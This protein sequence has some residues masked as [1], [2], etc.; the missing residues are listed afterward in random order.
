MKSK[1]L[2]LIVL[3][4]L[5]AWVQIAKAISSTTIQNAVTTNSSG[6]TFVI[7]SFTHV[8]V[9][10]TITGAARVT[11]QS[12]QV[13]SPQV[14]K[15]LTCVNADT[16]IRLSII[17]STGNY[18][19]V[20]NGSINFQ[21]PVS[22]CSGCTVTVK[23]TGS[24]GVA[25]IPIAD[26]ALSLVGGGSTSSVGAS[27]AVQASNGSGAFLDSGLT[28]VGGLLTGRWQYNLPSDTPVVYETKSASTSMVTTGINQMIR[29][30]GVYDWVD[31]CG[32]Y[33]NLVQQDG[34]NIDNIG[35]KLNAS[36]GGFYQGMESNY[37]INL[38]PPQLGPEWYIRLNP[39]GGGGAR[40]L[41][42]GSYS[43]DG[44]YSSLGINATILGFYNH[45][46]TQTMKMDTSAT[47]WNTTWYGRT[48]TEPHR[49]QGT[50]NGC[51]WIQQRNGDDTAYNNY[52]CFK[53]ING[54]TAGGQEF[55][56]S[57]SGSIPW[58]LTV[59][60][61]AASTFA[62]SAFAIQ[63]TTMASNDAIVHVQGP[64]TN[65][66]LNAVRAVGGHLSND[67][68]VLIENSGGGNALLSLQS[69]S[70]AG[71]DPF[72]RYY[73]LGQYW[74]HGI[75]NSVTGSPWKLSASNVLGTNDRLSVTTTGAL[76]LGGNC[77]SSAATAACVDALAGSVVIAAAGL[78]VTVNT[79]AVTANSQIFIM[80]D[81][82]LGTKLGVTC[83]T[84]LARTYAVTA[85][86]AGTSFVITTSAAPATFPA[87]LSYLVVN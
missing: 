12:T 8:L 64:G 55:A 34:F 5:V 57:T 42:G 18:T 25:A 37:C 67:W 20:V 62:T 21:A 48:S 77:T 81:S 1:L 61:Q 58:Y 63:S 44:T 66:I 70:T 35:N 27:G 3:I 80:E 10:T 53:D 17:E 69:D 31:T 39:T 71:G 85:R 86:T 76:T 52:P 68:Q 7:G 60:P 56:Y 43:H 41:I 30:I 13:S 46:G 29:N 22:G 50:A 11:Y 74:S 87:C 28:G 75:D 65:A 16:N 49:I 38:A 9:E 45:A 59:N 47:P 32:T 84:V 73:D 23:V 78:T 72:V 51:P 33:E 6:S 24:T 15:P 19:C 4:S 36:Y 79:T 26:V 14:Y 54:V 2:V 83:N 40:Q 82:S